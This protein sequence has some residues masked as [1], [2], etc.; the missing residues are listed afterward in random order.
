MGWWILVFFPERKR[1]IQ[2]TNTL[3]THVKT[4]KTSMASMNYFGSDMSNSTNTVVHFD[5]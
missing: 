3:L 1:G 4:Q 5:G 2:F